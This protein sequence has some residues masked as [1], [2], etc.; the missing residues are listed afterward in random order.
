MFV[1][2]AGGGRT[3]AQLAHYLLNENHTVHLVENRKEVISRIH[4]E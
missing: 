4:K 3:G 1:V 2:I